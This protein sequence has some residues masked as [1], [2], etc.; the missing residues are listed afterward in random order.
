MARNLA[1]LA[2]QTGDSRASIVRQAL[3]A[4]MKTFKY[5]P[6]KKPTIKVTHKWRRL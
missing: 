1:A 4:Y 2:L 5:K 3:A 6:Y